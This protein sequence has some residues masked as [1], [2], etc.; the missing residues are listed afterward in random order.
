MVKNC[1][2]GGWLCFIHKMSWWF[3]FFQFLHLQMMWTW[4]P[5][6]TFYFCYCSPCQMKIMAVVA[7]ITIVVVA[8]VAAAVEELCFIHKNHL[9]K[10]LKQNF[11]RFY[12]FSIL[13]FVFFQVLSIQSSHK[14]HMLFER[15]DKCKVAKYINFH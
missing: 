10:R 13:L 15:Y 14:H 11:S 5:T 2:K 7:E 6:Q 1:R 12:L 9:K 4:T 8:V 3:C